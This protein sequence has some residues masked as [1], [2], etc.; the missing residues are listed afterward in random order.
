MWSDL[1]VD[2]KT[3]KEF[4]KYMKKYPDLYEHLAQ[5]V[6]DNIPNSKPLIIDLGVGPGLLSLEIHKKIPNATI[7]GVDPSNKMLKLADENAKEAGFDKFKTILGMSEKIPV[8][9]N[10]TDVLVSRFSLVYWKNRKISFTE[11]NRVLKSNGRVILECLNK[12]FP[13][14]KLFLI[15]LHMLVNLAGKDVVRYHI[16]AYKKAYT[17]DQVEQL[18]ADAKFTIINKE[19]NK[20]D[21]KFIVVA[22]KN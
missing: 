11:I 10:S 15:K 22:K 5:V 20:K 21:W 6:L 7:F 4:E 2:D 14:W 9:N 3:A 18:L 17:I 1:L 16:D 13:R 8:N 19:G 12:D